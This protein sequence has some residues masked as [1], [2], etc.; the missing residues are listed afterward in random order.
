MDPYP[1]VL[2]LH[3]IFR[4]VALILGIVVTVRAFIGW[5]GGREWTERDRKLGSYFGISMD[6]Q[7][8]LGLLLYFVFSPLTTSALSNFSQAMGSRDVSFFAIEHPITMFLAVIFAHLGSIL[9]R[10]VEGSKSKFKR[11]AIYFTLAVLMMLSAMPWTQ[12]LLPGMG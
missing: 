12:P 9:A 10:R 8:L 5:F 2:A 7:L 11:A 1:V 6:I 3:N 4:W